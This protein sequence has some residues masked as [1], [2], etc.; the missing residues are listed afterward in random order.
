MMKCGVLF[1]VRI[2]FLS[3]IKTSVGLKRLMCFPL[4]PR[5]VGSNCAEAM[6]F[7]GDIN[8][9]NTFLRGRSK[10]GGPMS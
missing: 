7:K 10:A 1:E 5:F 4:D 3:I 6:D 9:Q 8:P 2:Y